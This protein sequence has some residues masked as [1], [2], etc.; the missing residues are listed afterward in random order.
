ML[1]WVLALWYWDWHT[2]QWNR[3]EN[4]ETDS[5]KYAQLIIDKDEKAV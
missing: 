5:H 2:D 1:V 4:K 3:I